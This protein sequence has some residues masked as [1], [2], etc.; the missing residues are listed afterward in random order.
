MIENM[1]NYN[2]EIGGGKTIRKG[3]IYFSHHLTVQMDERWMLEIIRLLTVQLDDIR[4]GNRDCVVINFPGELTTMM[5]E[6]A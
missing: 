4:T 2:F 3:K 5:D 1:E 6:Q